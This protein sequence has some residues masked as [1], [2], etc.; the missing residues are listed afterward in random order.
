[1][2]SEGLIDFHAHFLTDRYLA[3]ARAAGI[4]HPD[5]MPGWPTWSADGHLALMAKTGIAKAL[6][7][8][9]SPGVHFGDDRAARL[10]AQHVNDEAHRIQRSDPKRF[11]FFAALPLPDVGGAVVEAARA[12]DELGAVGV[13]LLTHHGDIY[14]G[15]P[16]LE[17]LWDALNSRA[18]L[19][20][21]HPTSPP[22]WER[23]PDRPRPMLEFLFE[24]ARS[25]IDLLL[26]GVPKRHPR[27]RFVAAHCGGA[28]PLVIER[29]ERFSQAFL[30]GGEPLGL[31]EQL[32]RIW[33][34]TA[35]TPMPDQLPSLVSVVGEGRILYGSD[36][37]FTPPP[38]VVG[39]LASLDASSPASATSWAALMTQ[40]A[41]RC[42]A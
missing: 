23:L 35:G 40:N 22:G 25:F 17:P 26:A 5:G 21:V 31:R 38:A 34:D 18:A 2:T 30:T 36:Y 11:G 9:S 24:T 10:L 7:S 8:I 16:A 37:C 4:A 42:L 14:L 28:L 32:A 13:S 20:H 12:I 15:D 6:L 1:V 27:V 19:V 33:F 3:E 41:T 29:A 39:Q